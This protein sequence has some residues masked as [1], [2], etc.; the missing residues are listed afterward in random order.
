MYR[1][2][3]DTAG[4]LTYVDAFDVVHYIASYSR[5]ANETTNVP[6]LLT[7][8]GEQMN[9]WLNEKARTSTCIACIYEFL[10][11]DGVFHPTVTIEQARRAGITVPCTTGSRT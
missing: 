4:P 7:C 10:L 6:W 2:P 11:D 3:R 5:T 9:A 8:C 1:Q